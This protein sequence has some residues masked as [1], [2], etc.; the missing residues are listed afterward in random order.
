MIAPEN[1]YNLPEDSMKQYFEPYINVKSQM[2][3]TV[4]IQR[5]PNLLKNPEDPSAN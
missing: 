5:N 1:N 2:E 4:L 3:E